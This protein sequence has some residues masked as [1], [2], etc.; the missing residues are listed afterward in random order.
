MTT[1]QACRPC[2]KRKVKCDLRQPCSNCSRRKTD[3]CIYPAVPSE[4]RIKRLEALVK[5]LG[6]DPD[7]G[8]I[9]DGGSSNLKRPVSSSQSQIQHGQGSASRTSVGSSDPIVIDADG[10]PLYLESYVLS[11]EMDPKL[12]LA[13]VRGPAGWGKMTVMEEDHEL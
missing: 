13:G 11:V 7:A 4:E 8:T 1:S 5:R 6:G 2:A 12:T 9:N 3:K 10:Q